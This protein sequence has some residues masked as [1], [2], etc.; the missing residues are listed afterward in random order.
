MRGSLRCRGERSLPARL[1]GVLPDYMVPSAF[2]WLPALPLL[3]NGKI[4]RGA[5]PA[6]DERGEVDFVA[7]A[8]A[9]EESIALIWGE[10]LDRPDWQA[11]LLQANVKRKAIWSLLRDQWKPGDAAEPPSGV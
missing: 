3:P 11:G 10:L 6:V 1:R 7:P 8:T 9:V 4:D 5:L 2:K